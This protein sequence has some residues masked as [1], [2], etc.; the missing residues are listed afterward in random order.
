M[1]DLPKSFEELVN[2]ADK[3]MYIAKQSG[4]NKTV[5]VF[6]GCINRM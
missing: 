4:R 6:I 1:E 3:N 2:Y 5:V